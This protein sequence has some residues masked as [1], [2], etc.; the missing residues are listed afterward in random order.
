[1]PSYSFRIGNAAVAIA[2]CADDIVWFGELIRRRNASLTSLTPAIRSAWELGL[3]L[4]SAR[5][6]ATISSGHEVPPDVH[7]AAR[8]PASLD[9]QEAAGVFALIR[10]LRWA[11]RS[12]PALFEDYV[13][14]LLGGAQLAIPADRNAERDA[15]WE[16]LNGCVCAQAASSFEVNPGAEGVDV[17]VSTMDAIWGVE[18]KVLY[19]SKIA[20]RIDSIIQG[21][22]QIE[23]DSRIARG[24]V[25]VNLTNCIDHSPFRASLRDATTF[26]TSEAAVAALAAATRS[27]VSAVRTAA[28]QRRFLADKQGRPRKKC[29]GVLF[30]AQ[31]VAVAGGRLDLFTRQVSLL[32]PRPDNSDHEFAHRYFAGWDAIAGP[33]VPDVGRIVSRMPGRY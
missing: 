27:A 6:L 21:V 14:E 8:L 30:V 9:V 25:A 5:A 29:R 10:A 17:L 23:S 15:F 7:L 4:W 19:S 32:R 20:R 22:K 24:F 12:Q 2:I 33:N 13:A 16:F 28:F 26:A 1:M 18:C 11:E 3:A 31:T